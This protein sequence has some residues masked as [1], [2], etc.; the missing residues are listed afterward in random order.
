MKTPSLTGHT[1]PKNT[2][3]IPELLLT[4]KVFRVFM[5]IAN[6]EFAEFHYD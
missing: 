5:E 3:I 4:F 2:Y 6:S 1:M